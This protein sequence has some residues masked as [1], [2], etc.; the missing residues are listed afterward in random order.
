[1]IDLTAL[2]ISKAPQTSNIS[3]PNSPT[4]LTQPNLQATDRSQTAGS[5]KIGEGQGGYVSNGVTRDYA[6]ELWMNQ[7][8]S[9]TLKVWQ[10]DGGVK[11]GQI[12]SRTFPSSR[13]ALNYFD[14]QYNGKNNSATCVKRFVKRERREISRLSQN[15]RRFLQNKIPVR[16]GLVIK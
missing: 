4:N 14:C 10:L 2:C 12:N 3:K 11:K 9:Y 13:E 6:Y 1:M 7:D 5:S 16:A 8:S 15:L